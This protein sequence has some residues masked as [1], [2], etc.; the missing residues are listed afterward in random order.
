GQAVKPLTFGFFHATYKGLYQGLLQTG[1]FLLLVVAGALLPMTTSPT[2]I[3]MGLEYLLRPLRIVGV[4]SQNVAT[5]VSVALRFVPILLDETQ[6]ARE[7]QWARGANLSNHSLKS[8]FEFITRLSIP[9]LLSAFRH[10]DQLVDAMTARG[11]HQ[12]PRTYLHDLKLKTP[13]YIV[14]A[15]TAA[16][17]A[18]AAVVS[19]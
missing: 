11:Y 7:A 14:L 9:V 10:A 15:A 8:S 17:C 3:T 2:E 13:D 12:G 16:V 18:A 19:F 5:M 4:S 6:S 1:R